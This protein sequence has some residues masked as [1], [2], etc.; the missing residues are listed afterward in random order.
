[1]Q[2]QYGSD[3]VDVSTLPDELEDVATGRYEVNPDG[4]PDRIVAKESAPREAWRHETHHGDA[5]QNPAHASDRDVLV[6]PTDSPQR[7]QAVARQEIEAAKLDLAADE[8]LLREATTPADIAETEARMHRSLSHI[9]DVEAGRVGLDDLNAPSARDRKFIEKYDAMDPAVQKAHKQE[10]IDAFNDERVGEGTAETLEALGYKARKDQKSGARVWVRP[11][12]TTNALPAVRE[13]DGRLVVA[14]VAPTKTYAPLERGASLGRTQ[15]YLGQSA[16]WKQFEGSLV[17]AEIAKRYP[18]AVGDRGALPQLEAEELAEIQAKVADDVQR[19]LA[20]VMEGRGDR[21]TSMEV[22]RH[23]MKEKGRKR[24]LDSLEAAP[25]PAESHRMLLAMTKQMNSSDQGNLAEDWYRKVVLGL[26]DEGKAKGAWKQHALMPTTSEKQMNR[27]ADVVYNGAVH[28]VKSGGSLTKDDV[29]QFTDYF[30]A[31]KQ[32]GEVAGIPVEGVELVLT[33][34]AALRA[35]ENK[36]VK[37][38]N[39]ANGKLKVTGFDANGVSHEI[40]SAASLSEL[41]KK[42]KKAGS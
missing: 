5:L 29:A 9:E 14:D 40:E 18:D 23:T 34:P 2:Q 4:I 37:L 17:D 24:L 25:T 8:A 1:M 6:D 10:V 33:N 28:E 19:D 11:D 41:L 31:V 27:F 38:F 35:S 26:S 22:L 42:L 32:H 30:A 20:A 39:A 16:S 12:G 15:E 3:G 7:R 13:I 21:E 36:L